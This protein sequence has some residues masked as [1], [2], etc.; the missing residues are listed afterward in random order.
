MDSDGQLTFDDDDGTIRYKQGFQFVIRRDFKK[1]LEIFRG[2]QERKYN[3]DMDSTV[4]IID[5][6]NG[7]FETLNLLSD[8]DERIIRIK[9]SWLA[10]E[11][12]YKINKFQLLDLHE[13]LRRVVHSYLR[14]LLIKQ[15]QRLDVPNTDL[16]VDLGRVYMELKELDKAEETLMYA[17]K[18]VPGDVVVMAHLSDLFF[19][20][21]D[22]KRSKAYL[23][24]AFLLD[25]EHVP[26]E[27][28]RSPTAR[29]MKLVTEQEG[30]RT[31]VKLWMPI[32][33]T[34]MNIFDVKNELTQD[35]VELLEDECRS[36]EETIDQEKSEREKLRPV[37][38]F[39]YLYLLDHMLVSGRVSDPRIIMYE[40]RLKNLDEEVHKKYIDKVFNHGE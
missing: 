22:L 18:L 15:F 7:A 27:D 24:H 20:K 2:L 29:E 6:W 28:L 23:R 36:L 1:A 13:Q 26:V 10:F 4:R 17:M 38:V 40:T 12:F 8:D 3:V 39:K 37:L 14:D 19:F 33:A 5:F 21:N 25:A 32:C 16:L 34:Y 31:N 11:D 30:Y 9:E 35:E